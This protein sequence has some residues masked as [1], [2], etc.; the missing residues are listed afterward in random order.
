MTGLS[1]SHH[2]S[3]G[4]SAARRASTASLSPVPSDPVP[5]S[6]LAKSPRRLRSSAG[7]RVNELNTAEGTAPEKV[8]VRVVE[9][10]QHA[11][12]C[13]SMIWQFRP[14]TY[15]CWEKCR[16]RQSARC[17]GDSFDFGELGI[18]RPDLAVEK[19]RGAL[20]VSHTALQR[21][22]SPRS[23]WCRNLP[24]TSPVL[25]SSFLHRAGGACRSATQVAVRRTAARSARADRH[26]AAGRGRRRDC[27]EGA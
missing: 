10:G 26:R 23:E 17:D 1:G 25:A 24:V 14:A 9:A 11:A 13:R 20:A 6:F 4:A 22:G 8:D 3:T 7:L 15:A 18:L 19:E 16:R 12:A 2:R 5:S 21:Q 27:P